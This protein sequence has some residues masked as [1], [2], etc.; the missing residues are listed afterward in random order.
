VL[1][2]PKSNN[3]IK[4]TMSSRPSQNQ[5][6]VAGALAAATAVSMI[7][8]YIASSSSTKTIKSLD[9]DDRVDESRELEG[10]SVDDTATSNIQTAAKKKKKKS[11]SKGSSANSTEGDA[12]AVPDEKLIH[13]QIEALDKKGKDF[14]K[15]KK[16]CF[17]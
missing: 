2:A 5:L 7:C 9:D 1:R 15:D 11:K 3:F 8:W 16:V 17:A 14:F 13:S 12:A 10:K 6:L 4:T